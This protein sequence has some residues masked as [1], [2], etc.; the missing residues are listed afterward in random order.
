LNI[1]S[2][3]GDVRQETPMRRQRGQISATGLV[4]SWGRWSRSGLKKY[5]KKVPTR[6]YFNI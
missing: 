3:S 5:K 2:R 1:V 6:D 4:T